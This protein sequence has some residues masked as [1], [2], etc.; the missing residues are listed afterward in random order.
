[1]YCTNKDFSLTRLTTVSVV[2]WRKLC[3]ALYLGCEAASN[4]ATPFES[5]DSRALSLLAT[6]SIL[7]GQ[8]DRN[9]GVK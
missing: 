1:M 9:S 7:I 2:Y 5:L 8:P 3:A 6:G 4:V